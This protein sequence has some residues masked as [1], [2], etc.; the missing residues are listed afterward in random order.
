MS[1]LFLLKLCNKGVV[2]NF[3]IFTEIEKYDIIILTLNILLIIEL[4]Y[5]IRRCFL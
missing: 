3:N 4:T 5:F 1:I 2:S